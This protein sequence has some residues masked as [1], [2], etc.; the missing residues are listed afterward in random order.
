MKLADFSLL[1]FH[2]SWIVG[3]HITAG[4]SDGGVMTGNRHDTANKEIVIIG[5]MPLTGQYSFIG[6]S[7][8]TAAEEAIQAVNSNQSI[9]A[10]YELSLMWMDTKVLLYK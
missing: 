7:A 1:L 8:K 9:L 4:Q 2:A 10:G 6:Q 3:L 5:F